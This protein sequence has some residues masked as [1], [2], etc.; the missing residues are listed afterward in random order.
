MK[1]NFVQEVQQWL[2]PGSER[3]TKVFHIAGMCRTKFYVDDMKLFENNCLSSRLAEG[4]MKTMEQCHLNQ[5]IQLFTI[6]SF[7]GHFGRSSERIWMNSS[8]EILKEMQR[9]QSQGPCQCPASTLPA[10]QRFLQTF[11]SKYID[12]H[13]FQTY[14]EKQHDTIWHIRVSLGRTFWLRL[15]PCLVTSQ[16][17]HPTIASR[18]FLPTRKCYSFEIFVVLIQCWLCIN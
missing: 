11:K 10:L 14:C 15:P 13:K 12:F 4:K 18:H 8:F 3:K 6:R 1:L 17:G 5:V 2:L 16:T 9:M 7:F